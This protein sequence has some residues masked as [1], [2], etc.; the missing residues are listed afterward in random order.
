MISPRRTPSRRR[1]VKTIS[2][3][4]RSCFL[5]DNQPVRTLLFV[6]VEALAI[7]AADALAGDDSG[8]ANGSPLARFFAD[9]ACIA[10]RPTLDPEN[11]Q[12]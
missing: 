10:F 5:L 11:S 7:I 4:R 2:S 6:H 9:L 12:V 3:S 1:L 8:S